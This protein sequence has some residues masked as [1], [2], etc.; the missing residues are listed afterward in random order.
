MESFHITPFKKPIDDSTPLL[1]EFDHGSVDEA[2]NPFVQGH[3]VEPSAAKVSRVASVSLRDA[4]A[5]ASSPVS[6]NQVA[7][8]EVGAR[9]TFDATSARDATKNLAYRVADQALLDALHKCNASRFSN[10][11]SNVYSNAEDLKTYHPQ[12]GNRLAVV[13]YNQGFSLCEQGARQHQEE[14]AGLK[15]I[16]EIISQSDHFILSGL[17]RQQLALL[18]KLEQLKF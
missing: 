17:D 7:L 14:L 3:A 4:S 12:L 10:L 16:G 8:T 2:S 15:Q 13:V 9:C 18:N 1:S 5:T 11:L 6:L